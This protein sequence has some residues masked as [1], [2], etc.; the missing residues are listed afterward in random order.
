MLSHARARFSPSPFRKLRPIPMLAAI[1]ALAAPRLALAGAWVL[2]PGEHYSTVGGSFFS[3]DYYYD[4]DGTKLSFQG[5]GLHEEKGLFTYNEFGWRKSRSFVIGFPYTSVTRR[6]TN[7][8]H[9]T[10]RTETGF[11]DLLLGV[12]FRLT[13]GPQALSLEAD[14]VPPLG[15]NRNLSPRLGDGAA[16]L[17]GNLAYGAPIAKAGFFELSG[18]Y[19]FFTETQAPTNEMLASATVAFWLGKAV[20]ISG[21]YD[22]VFGAS[23]QD[24]VYQ[25]LRVKTP[26]GRAWTSSEAWPN[27]TTDQINVQSVSPMLLYRLDDH[28][29]LMAG[30]SHTFSG[31]N[32]LHVDRIYVALAMRQSKLGPLQGFMGG[33]R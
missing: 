32:A 4:Q 15:Y 5:G 8:G 31:K 26:Q 11:G 16:S 22:G 25:A 27:T 17:I 18:G 24:T 9:D 33:R 21:R 10:T 6:F 30:S 7:N 23:S 19:R 13:G 3:S 2:A 1:I 28:L 14:W 12:K 29:D 20:L